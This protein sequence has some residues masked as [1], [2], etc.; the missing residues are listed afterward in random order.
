MSYLA[1]T[2]SKGHEY[3]KVMESYREGGKVKH[4]VL[5]NIGTLQNLYK[6]LP[7]AVTGGTQT[8]D[9][10]ARDRSGVNV[11]LEPVRCRVHGAP[12]MMYSISE[13]LGIQDL[14]S[15]FF[16]QGTANGIT[17][18][19]S[20]L[21]AA[22]HRACEPGSKMK[23]AEWFGY[24]SL[25]DR[26]KVDSSVFTSQ[27]F[28]EQMDGITAD[29]IKDFETALFRKIITQFPD[30]QEKMSTLSTDFT[31][32]YTY[33]NNR[34]Y[35]CVIAQ[36]GHSKEGRTGQRIFCVAVIISPLLGIPIATMVYEGNQNDKTAL[37]NFFSELTTRLSEV[38]DPQKITYV[39]DGGGASEE[40]LEMIPGNYI[41]RGSLKSSPELY[42]VPR[43][44]YEEVELTDDG[45]THVT[46]YRGKAVQFG[47]ERTV[48]ISLSEALKDGQDR[49]TNKQ[50]AKFMEKI[51]EL[52][53]RLNNPRATTDK[54]LPAIEERVR[55]L[56][57]SEYHLDE[58]IEISYETIS[59]IDPLLERKFK[60]AEK[61]SAKKKEKI[62]LKLEDGT[63]ITKIEDIPKVQVVTSLQ[64]VVNETKRQAMSDKYYGKHLLVTD[65]DTWS[66]E[67]II[68]V[69]RDQE[70]IERFFRD[71]K[72]V[73]HFS[74]RPTFHW[75]DQKLRVHVM[76]CYLGL[77]LCRTA[78]YLLK[79]RF[80]YSITCSELLDQLTRV[81]E[82]LVIMDINGEK[83][84][85][86][87]VL[88]ELN[89]KDR[90]T[91]SKVELLLEDLKQHP[92]VGL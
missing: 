17:R 62:V 84:D 88:S 45:C 37:K 12:F 28:W 70:H 69:Y 85:P 40:V 66:T 5:Y 81:Q 38:V 43:D 24:T 4:R 49:E 52:N 1:K 16:P 86:K 48:I 91:W 63:E 87:T 56:L 80:D 13:W 77:T 78:Q 30:L 61:N 44:S 51:D 59:I 23:F 9:Q 89:G 7:N 53:I 11:H 31:N 34:N 65:Q 47:K 75:T 71:T 39:F 90:E 26:L 33:I 79:R 41:T 18:P 57:A 60:N 8:P 20:L 72:D 14:M 92:A 35:R 67:K 6:L 3:Y 50:T 73:R 42:D 76:I 64:A 25:P 83:V 27:H 22:I 68:S 10:Q 15:Q 32:Y 82:C 21:L 46:A 36:M 58:F 54:R 19:M 2:V 55:K 74:V 29:Q